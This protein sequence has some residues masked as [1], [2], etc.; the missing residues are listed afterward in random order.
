MNKLPITALTAGALSAAALTLAAAAAAA[1]S[2]P[3]SVDQTVN[4]LK[5]D[6]YTVFV[7]KVGA[8]PVDQCTVAAVRPGQ[9]YMP[10]GFRNARSPR[11]HPHH[12]DGQDGLRRH[13][14]LSSHAPR[15]ATQRAPPSLR[16]FANGRKRRISRTD[17]CH[18]AR[19][20]CRDQGDTVAERNRTDRIPGVTRKLLCIR[21]I[22]LLGKNG[23]GASFRDLAGGPP[24][25]RRRLRTPR[26]R[27]APQ[28]RADL[29]GT[30]LGR[31]GG[32]NLLERHRRC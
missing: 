1:P 6:G 25:H 30:P 12:R 3:S 16:C 4:Q 7:N 24:R 13:R 2:G 31:A 21:F 14:L 32:H 15:E 18:S 17:L 22:I 8:A 27:A 28:L 29:V 5:A 23:F 9:T 19:G 10:V 11:R 20:L 26:R